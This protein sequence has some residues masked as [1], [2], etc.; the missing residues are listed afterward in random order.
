MHS[1]SL[2]TY[3]SSISRSLMLASNTSCALGRVTSAP[4]A[5]SDE[6]ITMKLAGESPLGILQPNLE[7]EELRLHFYA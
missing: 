2:S 5:P 4:N 1:F 6:A 7:Q 3:S